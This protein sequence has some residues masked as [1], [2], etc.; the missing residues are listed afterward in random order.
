MDFRKHL[1]LDTRK[2]W[3]SVDHILL[4]AE[5][6]GWSLDRIDFVTGLFIFRKEDIQLNFYSTTF[7]VSTTLKHPKHKSRTQ[8]HRKNLSVVQI[9]NVFDNPRVHTGKGYFKKKP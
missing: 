7:S 3:A 9:M 5:T 1:P 6:E 8:L 4:H 2:R